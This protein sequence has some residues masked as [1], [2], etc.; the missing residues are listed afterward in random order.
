MIMKMFIALFAVF[1]AACSS[2]PPKPDL[3]PPAAQTQPIT[4]INV[5]PASAPII[6][7]VISPQQYAQPVPQY[8]QAPP[9]VYVQPRV[10]VPEGYVED[11]TQTLRPS[12]RGV[13]PPEPYYGP[14]QQ[15]N[16]W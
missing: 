11:Y 8:Y 12:H 4:I 1:L 9:Q 2:A 13:T 7:N 15:S 5:P 16:W 3:P 14:V 10:Y 6:N